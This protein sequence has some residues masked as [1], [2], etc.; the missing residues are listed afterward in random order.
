MRHLSSLI[1]ILSVTLVA[2]LAFSLAPVLICADSFVQP[3]DEFEADGIRYQVVAL[4]EGATPGGV[5]V[6]PYIDPMFGRSLYAG[7]IAIPESVEY[8]Y[9]QYT[10]IGI[11]PGAFQNV[12]ALTGV[13]L[14]GTI[15]SIGA[16]AFQNTSMLYSIEL[17]DSVEYIG[18]YAFDYSGVGGVVIPD[19]VTELPE[20]AL[21]GGYITE[22]TLPPG[23]LLVHPNA[24]GVSLK[25]IHV[26]K[27]NPAFSAVDGVLF[28]AG[29]KMLLLYPPGREE[30]SY[31][32]PDGVETIASGAFGYLPY[33]AEIV[34]PD[35]LL[36]IEAKAFSLIRMDCSLYFHSDYPPSIE[37][38]QG[39]R[40]GFY[41]LLSI[42]PPI[43]AIA[44]YQEAW[45]AI[46]AFYPEA[47]DEPGDG[48]D[49][50][51]ALCFADGEFVYQVT[52]EDTAIVTGLRDKDKTGAVAVPETVSYGGNTY[53]VTGLAEECFESG[54]MEAVLL[55]DAI[56]SIGD[57]A[58][59]G[60]ENLISVNIPASLEAIPPMAFGSCVSLETVAFADD[61]VL[62]AV[63][64]GAFWGCVSLKQ[65]TLPESLAV[66]GGFA[67]YR[68]ESL[69]RIVIPGRVEE[70]QA[71]TFYRCEKLREAVLPACLAY[72]PADVFVLCGNLETIQ[73]AEGNDRFYTDDGVLYGYVWHVER[74][75][76]P[77][78]AEE[79]RTLIL[80]P[81]GR[82]DVSFII[83]EGVEAIMG[84][85]FADAVDLAAVTAP[86]TL[87]YV[88]AAFNPALESIT[89]SSEAPPIFAGN[90][91][92]GLD[93]VLYVPT[94]EGVA[95]YQQALDEYKPAGRV[96]LE[97]KPDNGKVPADSSE[98]SDGSEPGDGG[99]PGDGSSQGNIGNSS[100]NNNRPGSSTTHSN[101]DDEELFS[102]VLVTLPYS[103]LVPTSDYRSLQSLLTDAIKTASATGSDTAS[104]QL[105]NYRSL[106]AETLRQLATAAAAGGKRCLIQADTVVGGITQ[107]S[108][109]FNPAG[110]ISPLQLLRGAQNKAAPMLL[111]CS[112]DS[113]GTRQVKELFE[114]HFDN[115]AAVLEFAQ[116]GSFPM[117]VD[118][119]A[120]VNLAGLN[121]GSLYFYAYDSGA[122]TYML[123]PN[124]KYSI[125][126]QGYLRFTTDRAGY[127]V[128]TD[129]P[130]FAKK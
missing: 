5:Q 17:P 35:S 41:S 64:E 85:A 106:D 47:P 20:Y 130:L 28:D 76:G 101:A 72:L 109:T 44:A 115:R 68:C 19:K 105:V 30:Q 4:A 114:R 96:T 33:L 1:R 43:A 40:N 84:G 95:V 10:V 74:L 67:F 94:L 103:S 52:G 45:G 93:I 81:S 77:L 55:P 49:G 98:P 63:G 91:F 128:V 58:F 117:P 22:I 59:Y 13:S 60:C 27:G 73:I 83:P 124:L 70:I 79:K 31:R 123:L 78:F 71:Y 23:L 18:P 51:E 42:Y 38:L 32:V 107:A 11:G 126:K 121:S 26:A 112:V 6:A 104:L 122:N 16:Y 46:D 108:L 54:G 9:Q 118:I 37:D 61:G 57:R 75:K 29:G 129:K 113:R 62:S 8:D 25:E 82:Q 48:E 89:F 34:F 50:E 3:G 7:K 110:A 120:K 53:Q 65:I 2:M 66:I 80:Y 99:E 39:F 21:S 125:D 14:P 15:T 100:G 36:K 111:T 97:P 119:A 102:G 12:K 86:E 127:L 24:F 90:A 116:K 69:E 56:R 88:G 87:V 92:R